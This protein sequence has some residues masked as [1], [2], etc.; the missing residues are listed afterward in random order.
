MYI[1]PHCFLKTNG[2]AG[3][4]LPITTSD[5]RVP[6]VIIQAERSNTGY[7][8]LGDNQVSSTNY[9]IDLN[10]ADSVTIT[11]ETFGLAGANISLQDIWFDASVTGDGISV[12]YMERVE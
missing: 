3:T 1:K 7:I 10:T 6:G 11:A 4:E 5:I 8:Y 12:F 2:A 9:G